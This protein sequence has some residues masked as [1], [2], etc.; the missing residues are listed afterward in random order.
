M[1]QKVGEMKE[2]SRGNRG[3]EEYSKSL[4][5]YLAFAMPINVTK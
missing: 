3:G 1:K 4:L 5:K 2:R